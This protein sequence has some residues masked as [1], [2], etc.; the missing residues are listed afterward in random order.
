LTVDI[1]MLISN[2]KRKEVEKDMTRRED[3]LE[4]LL[5][6]TT[7]LHSEKRRGIIEY[8]CW[9][10][11]ADFQWKEKRS[12]ERHDKTETGRQFRKDCWLTLKFYTARKK[13]YN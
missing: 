9:R 10:I 2:G 13:R 4:R 11:V 5:T 6:D 8:D 3:N 12:K 7:L 1:S